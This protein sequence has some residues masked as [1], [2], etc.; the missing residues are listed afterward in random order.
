M[1]EWVAGAIR[2]AGGDPL[3]VGRS[4]SVSGIAAIPDLEKGC[5]SHLRGV[6]TA[7][8]AAENAARVGDGPAAAVVTAVSMPLLRPATLRFLAALTDDRRAVV[9]VVDWELFGLLAVYPAR[10]LREALFA[11]KR[12]D[13]LAG[14][15]DSIPIRRVEESE[16]AAW[17]EDGSS[18]F[19]VRTKEDHAAAEGKLN[20]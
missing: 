7:L 6:I 9:P 2:N 4:S 20:P 17:G 14:F 8:D 15:L 11:C 12:G 10:L 16:W 3:I 13:D 5:D 1:V 19:L 18:F